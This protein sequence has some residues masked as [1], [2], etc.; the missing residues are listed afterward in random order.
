M[1]ATLQAIFEEL[2][3]LTLAKLKRDTKADQDQTA[4]FKD[5]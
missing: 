4:P 3:E 1:D 5:K 2:N